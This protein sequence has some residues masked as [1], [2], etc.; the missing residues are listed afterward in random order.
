MRTKFKAWTKPYLEEHQEVQLTLE[1]VR[2]LNDDV[3]LVKVNSF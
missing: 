3:Y 1:Q 2:E